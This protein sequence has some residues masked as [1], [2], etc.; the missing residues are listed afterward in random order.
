MGIP[1]WDDSIIAD[2]LTYQDNPW[3]TAWLGDLQIP[4][5]VSVRCQPMR[6]V[7]KKKKHGSD[8]NKSTLYGYKC[9]E[10]ILSVLIWT[11]AQWDAFQTFAATIWPRPG[12]PPPDKSFPIRHPDTAL[13]GINSVV[14]I[15]PSSSTRGQVEQSKMWIIKCLEEFNPTPTNKN[16]TVTTAGAEV[17]VVKEFTDP[18]AANSVPPPPSQTD[19]GPGG[20]PKKPE[21]GPY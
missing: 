21:R 11:P 5:L 18:K 10:V 16:T 4:G 3:D 20:P 14:V 8:T 2:G 19:T 9:Q 17:A 12:K 1:F 7:N 6:E 15:A 13:W